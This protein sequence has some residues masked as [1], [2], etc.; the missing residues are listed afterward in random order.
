M[1]YGYLDWIALRC[2]WRSKRGRT[3][4]RPEQRPRIYCE[5]CETAWSEAQRGPDRDAFLGLFCVV[6]DKRDWRTCTTQRYCESGRRPTVDCERALY[7]TCLD[8]VAVSANHPAA[9]S[10]LTG[11]RDT[12]SPRHA[13]RVWGS[14]AVPIL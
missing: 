13:A 8:V 12:N 1:P 10:G 5:A 9:C 11:L 3:R 14:S 7:R 4:K 2:A 6:V